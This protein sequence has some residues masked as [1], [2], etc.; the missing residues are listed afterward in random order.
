MLQMPIV[1]LYICGR[2]GNAGVEG[3]RRI[4]L[5]AGGT[6]ATCYL[7][8]GMDQHTVSIWNKMNIFTPKLGAQA[9]RWERSLNEKKRI[10]YMLS[11]SCRM[12]SMESGYAG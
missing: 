10:L 5:F 8:R 9:N 2:V 12:T 11:N 1:P 7:R 3:K 4:G 6:G